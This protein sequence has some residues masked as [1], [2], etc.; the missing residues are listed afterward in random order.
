MKENYMHYAKDIK[1]YF[2]RG[3]GSGIGGGGGAFRGSGIGGGGGA[4]RGPPPAGIGG[5]GAFRGPPGHD[6]GY[7]A[8]GY[9]WGAHGYGKRFR[10]NYPVGYRY[11][12]GYNYP[13][14][15]SLCTEINKDPFATSVQIECCP[16][17]TQCLADW[18]NDNNPYYLCK[19]SCDE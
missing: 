13:A 18:N 7:G 3:R 12:I 4:F 11:P 5:G 14:F 16:G 10:Y 9:P 8:G 15:P 2:P 19:K 6:G 1:E 17:L